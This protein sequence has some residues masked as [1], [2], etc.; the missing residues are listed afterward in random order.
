M[1]GLPRD[2]EANTPAVLPT[3]TAHG[4]HGGPGFNPSSTLCRYTYACVACSAAHPC[5]PVQ[6]ASAALLQQH[7]H[8]LLR[9]EQRCKRLRHVRAGRSMAGLPMGAASW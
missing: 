3:P 5:N 2:P 8:P 1:L 6:G 9:A 4:L 7:Y